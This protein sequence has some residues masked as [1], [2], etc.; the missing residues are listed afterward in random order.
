MAATQS[1]TR[2]EINV[3]MK[4]SLATSVTAAAEI[5]YKSLHNIHSRDVTQKTTTTMFLLEQIKNLNCC[6][7]IDYCSLVHCSN[8]CSTMCLL[9][10]MGLL[11][12]TTNMMLLVCVALQTPKSRRLSFR[13]GGRTSGCAKQDTHDYSHGPTQRKHSD[14]TF[15]LKIIN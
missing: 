1:A 3:C 2:L 11:F 6:Y 10:S 12:T 14:R 13:L 7:T 4:P 5:F 8:T 9:T 15:P